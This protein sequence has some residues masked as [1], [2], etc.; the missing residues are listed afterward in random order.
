MSDF[1]EM[2]DI[3]ISPSHSDVGLKK[4]HMSTHTSAPI[5]RVEVITRGARRR[6]HASEK[7]AIVLESLSP[8]VVVSAV[9]RQHGIGSGQLSTWR[10]EMR[11]GKLSDPRPPFLHFA[12][13]MV[14]EPPIIQPLPR[15]LPN[16]APDQPAGSVATFQKRQQTRRRPADGGVIE[17]VLPNGVV[18]RV[19]GD[20]DQAALSRI[21]AALKSA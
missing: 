14:A 3:S 16:G 13:A 18:V 9:C 11:E 19:G 20:V 2:D 12:E 10:Q 4:A 6:W 1:I 5:E 21:L 15:L 17:I 7:R 8:G